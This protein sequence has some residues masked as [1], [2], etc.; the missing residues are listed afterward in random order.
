[1][2]SSLNST[3]EESLSAVVVSG[4][5]ELQG[6]ALHISFSHIC[7]FFLLFLSRVIMRKAF[8]HKRR[9][10]IRSVSKAVQLVAQ[11]ATAKSGNRTK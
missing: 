9:R 7:F 5:M 4:Y 3:R 1:M 10:N 11:Y 2:D 8:L 6:V